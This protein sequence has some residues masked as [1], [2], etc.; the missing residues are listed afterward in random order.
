MKQPEIY[1]IFFST[2]KICT[3]SMNKI[4]ELNSHNLIE[5]SPNGHSNA[6]NNAVYLSVFQVFEGLPSLQIA[7]SFWSS[8]ILD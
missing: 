3:S 8:Y 6:L 4:C 5:L 7:P 2:H 1:I